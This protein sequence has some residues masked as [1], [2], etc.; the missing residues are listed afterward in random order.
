MSTFRDEVLG[1]VA[2]VPEGAVVTYGQLAA[3]VGRPR[4]ARAVGQIMRQGG[5]EGIPYHRVIKHDGSLCEGFEFAIPGLQRELLRAEGVPFTREGRVNVAAC[6]W[7]GT[8]PA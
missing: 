6:R 1:L 2:R 8:T 7:E 5:V 3:M 4:A